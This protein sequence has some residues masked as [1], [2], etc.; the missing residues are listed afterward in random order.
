MGT[1]TGDVS[2]WLSDI[3][4]QDQGDHAEDRGEGLYGL[5]DGTTILGVLPVGD[6][7][8]WRTARRGGG[9]VHFLEEGVCPVDAAQPILD[10]WQR[11]ASLSGDGE[12]A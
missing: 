1:T 2:R 9:A 11:A 12:V 4:S 8:Y 7:S 10:A 3:I 5:S 6:V